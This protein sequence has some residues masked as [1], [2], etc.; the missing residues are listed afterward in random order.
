MVDDRAVAAAGKENLRSVVL[1]RRAFPITE[2][3]LRL[4]ASAAII[5]LSIK[6]GES[7]YRIPA[8]NGT[9]RRL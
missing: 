8:A 2:T 1:R 6:W 5:G 3:L 9:P 7:G 4:M